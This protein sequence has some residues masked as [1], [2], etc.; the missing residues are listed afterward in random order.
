M[1]PTITTDHVMTWKRAVD[2]TSAGRVE[3]DISI[4]SIEPETVKVY[5]RTQKGVSAQ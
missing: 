4:Q 3:L 1:T 5:R 2:F